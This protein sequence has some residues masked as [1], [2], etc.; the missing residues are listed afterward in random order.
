MPGGVAG[1]EG[2]GGHATGDECTWLEQGGLQVGEIKCMPFFLG[3]SGEADSLNQLCWLNS[4]PIGE[5]Y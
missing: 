1:Q 5:M 4:H 2:R 3:F